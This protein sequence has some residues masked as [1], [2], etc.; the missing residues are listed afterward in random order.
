MLPEQYKIAV[1]KDILQRP[2]QPE[3]I[4]TFIKKLKLC[5]KNQTILLNKYCLNVPDKI[6]IADL[7]ISPRYYYKLVQHIHVCAYDAMRRRIRYKI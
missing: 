5:R 4:E 7:K 6:Q 3:V 1:I 2:E